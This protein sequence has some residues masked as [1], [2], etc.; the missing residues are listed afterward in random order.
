MCNRL[1]EMSIRASINTLRSVLKE[2]DKNIKN[3]FHLYLD[4]FHKNYSNFVGVMGN[5]VFVIQYCS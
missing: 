2:Y 1:Y 4:F 5:S 3:Q